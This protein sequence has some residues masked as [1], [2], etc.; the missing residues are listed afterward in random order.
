MSAA[1][2]DICVCTYRRPQLADTLR[3]LA[4]L[5]LAPGRKIRVI[6]A[7]NDDTPS[8]KNLAEQTA[9]NSGLSL[10]YVHAPA[11][12]ISVARNACLDAATAPL[13][14][15]VDDDEIVS[16]GWLEDLAV[17]LE[18][19]K[20][21]AVLGPVDAVYPAD[22]PLWMRKGDFHSSRP[23]WVKNEIISGYT[24]N[25]LLRREAPALKGLRFRPDLGRSGGED[26]MF[27]T[28]MHRAGGKITYAPGA[29]VSEAVTP[30]RLTLSWLTKRSFR[31]GQTHGA[32]LLERG[33]G[34]LLTRVRNIFA[35]A[36]KILFCFAALLPNLGRKDRAAFW[37]L[38]GVMHMGAVARLLG[39]RELEQYG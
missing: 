17:A 27:F 35:G 30:E 6:V 2:I 31:S 29:T 24:C 36:S 19:D 9:S 23:V 8:A 22:C 16:P 25:V 3:S 5:A 12:N 37:W 21:D 33:A 39:K 26:T 14:A 20:A 11:R 4:G 34:S 1:D 15:F 7:D 13:A 10:S 28:A 38:R 32:V 18:R